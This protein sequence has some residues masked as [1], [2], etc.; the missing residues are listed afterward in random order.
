MD[1]FI[2][3][4][5]SFV[6]RSDYIFSMKKSP[7]SFSLGRISALIGITFSFRACHFL[8]PLALFVLV[9]S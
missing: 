8:M 7:V 4:Q 1:Y 6:A 3:Y 9:K 2:N 5:W